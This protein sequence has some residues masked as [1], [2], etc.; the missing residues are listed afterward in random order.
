MLQPVPLN[1]TFLW[2]T[3]GIGSRPHS[4]RS[5][6]ARYPSRCKG[7]LGDAAGHPEAADAQPGHDHARG[8][9]QSEHGRVSERHAPLIAAGALPR[10][11]G[12]PEVAASRLSSRGTD[13]HRTQ[14]SKQATQRTVHR[15]PGPGTQNTKLPILAVNSVSSFLRE[16]KEGPRRFRSTYV[17]VLPPRASAPP[18]ARTEC[19]PS[20]LFRAACRFLVLA[21]PADAN[22]HSRSTAIS[23]A[24][25]THDSRVT[26]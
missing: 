16:R 13:P 15:H 17:A 1:Q 8:A 4:L 3:C 5:R 14:R 9:A 24:L 10:G 12:P 2:N 7:K 23:T 25:L 19:Q 21:A 26:R 11:R 18:R 6:R 20:S 22:G